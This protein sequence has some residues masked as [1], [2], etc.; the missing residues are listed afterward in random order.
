MFDLVF[1]GHHP[2]LTREKLSQLATAAGHKVRTSFCSKTT[3]VVASYKAA[4]EGTTKARK[5]L[6]KGVSLMT[7]EDF[8]KAVGYEPEQPQLI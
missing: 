7:Y 5:A 4:K 8:L 6:E 3:L 2:E 1:T